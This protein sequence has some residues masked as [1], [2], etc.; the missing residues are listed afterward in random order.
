MQETIAVADVSIVVA[1][2]SIAALEVISA[3][4]PETTREVRTS[5]GADYLTPSNAFNSDERIERLAPGPFG[6]AA[7]IVGERSLPVS[8]LARLAR[9]ATSV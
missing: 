9:T 8:E 5:I 1:D 3:A 4:T 7:S 2:A 6:L